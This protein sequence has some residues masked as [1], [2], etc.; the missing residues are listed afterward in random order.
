M[1][2]NVRRDGRLWFLAHHGSV[3]HDCFKALSDALYEATLRFRLAGRD[4][5]AS[6]SISYDELPNGSGRPTV[7]LVAAP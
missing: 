6:L 2:I 4:G 3:E 7:E 1:R 5:S